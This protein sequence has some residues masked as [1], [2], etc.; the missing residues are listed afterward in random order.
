[1]KRIFYK[2]FTIIINTFY[3]TRCTNKYKR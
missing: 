3:F 2:L 1:V